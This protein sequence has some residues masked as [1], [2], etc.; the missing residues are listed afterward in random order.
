VA[1]VRV[2]ATALLAVLLAGALAVVP[3]APVLAAAAP[4]PP[5]E[6]PAEQ[7]PAGQAEPAAPAA[8]EPVE[9]AAG[10][11]GA[12]ETGGA[13][14]PT[15]PT[16]PAQPSETEPA[17]PSE[18]AE[19]TGSEPATE[20][21]ESSGSTPTGPSGSATQPGA[22]ESP[23]RDGTINGEDEDAAE[24][25]ADGGTDG[26]DGTQPGE[27]AQRAA[28]DPAAIDDR[29]TVRAGGTV[30]I[31][32]TA[33]DVTGDATVRVPSPPPG[34]T[35]VVGDAVDFTPAVGFKGDVAF[36]YELV[37]DGTVRATA[38][39]R[40]TVLPPAGLAAAD[41]HAVTR[42]ASEGHPGHVVD[43]LANDVLPGTEDG[44]VS[45]EIVAA[46][47]HGTASAG[48]CPFEFCPTGSVV[49]RPA[50]GFAGR[51]TFVYGLRAGGE[52]VDTATVTVDV[53]DLPEGSVVPVDDTITV[54]PG[55]TV[56]FDPTRNDVGASGHDVVTVREPSNG[57]LGGPPP[58]SENPNL[59]QY[60][61]DAG[62]A[63]GV[64]TFTYRLQPPVIVEA[65]P[66]GRV[67]V[68]RVPIERVPFD[69][70]ADI[71]VLQL[72]A[73][74]A[75]ETATVTVIVNAPIS[76]PDTATT[77]AGESVDV[78]VG[79]NDS[80]L[81]GHCLA[82]PSPQPMAG[83]AQAVQPGTVTYTPP[84][85]F[86]GT[87]EFV[88]GYTPGCEG[89]AIVART[90]VTV[91]V[92]PPTLADDAATT[93]AGPVAGLPVTI[94]VLAND[95]RAA[96]RFRLEVDQPAGGATAV[97]TPGEG[98]PVVRY[99]PRA[100][101]A[102][103][104][105]FRYR[106]LSGDATVAEAT[107]SVRVLR[108]AAADDAAFTTAGEAVTVDAGANDTLADGVRAVIVAEP[109]S[110]DA[111]IVGESRATFSYAPGAGFGA[112]DAFDYALVAADEDGAD[113]ELARAT[114]TVTRV[115]AV[116]DTAR[117]RFRL[118]VVVDVRANDVGVVEAGGAV[119]VELDPAPAGLAAVEVREGVVEV[120]PE[121]GF[122]GAAE[123]T[124]RLVHDGRT[125]DTGTVAVDVP[126]ATEAVADAAATD[127]GVA[128][129]VDV[130]ANDENAAGLDVVVS[131]APGRG[132]AEVG[133]DGRVTYTPG[134]GRA[135]G[136]RFGYALQVPGTGER[137]ATAEVVVT[138]RA[139][140][141]GDDAMTVLSGPV[142]RPEAVDVLAN[143]RFAAGFAVS[144]GDAAHGDA[145][146]E[147]DR[148]VRYTP[149]AGFAGADTVPY[150]LVEPDGSVAA[151]AV[152][153]VRVDAVDARD[154]AATTRVDEDIRLAVLAND[155]APSGVTVSLAAPGP[156]TGTVAVNADGSL[157]YRPTAV[158]TD[159]FR[160]SLTGVVRG[161]RVVLDTAVVRVTVTDVPPPGGGGP[162]PGDPDPGDPDPGDPVDPDPDPGAGTP[163]TTPPAT[164]RTPDDVRVRL[165]VDSASP[166]AEVEVT[167]SGCPASEPVI[168][169]VDGRVAARP[170]ANGDGEFRATVPAPDEVGRH[171]VAVTCG[172]GTTTSDL[173]VVVTT[174]Q[175]GTQA[176]AGAAAAAAALLLFFL[177]SGMGLNPTGR[178]ARP[179]ASPGKVREP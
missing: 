119:T 78:N 80:V 31:A 94:D 117:S 134:P 91:T 147:G 33:N 71:P 141:P 110:G 5:A 37:L 39:V 27:P 25:A 161:T 118:P 144:V 153:R 129:E 63:G 34:T 113:T 102:G 36:G 109:E 169:E 137:I 172:A 126:E 178:R 120:T 74:V 70:L 89:D 23:E 12:G 176:P 158:G 170:T 73:V 175:A 16:E 38:T 163:G 111:T 106:L 142:P 48:G 28:A 140:Q 41:D 15:E 29:A 43:V 32:V 151:S 88:Y 17:T 100:G 173:D 4:P 20:P 131:A 62:F 21:S 108:V 79:A 107:V 115:E 75:A 145:V 8:A 171:R 42:T 159:G 98:R 26:T 45:V 44:D 2:G 177:L 154:D 69:S 52:V 90:T 76:Q 47:A 18:P 59:V 164:P 96:R 60:T 3:A 179:A 124:Y 167:G 97:R 174:M 123:L 56:V 157:D 86:V 58:G 103:T 105:T 46:P 51:D 24:D 139:P 77:T 93:A 83:S 65:V 132:T 35:A 101:F 138:V 9:P 68:D 19:P 160:Y 128:V 148:V 127:A 146:L 57:R 122:S 7:A 10:T 135:G 64:D 1:R 125:V 53:G 149:D 66:L 67:P 155:V 55:E 114:V 87:D 150:D 116:P 40:V 6:A 49:Y 85:G 11:S 112:A 162:G 95:D 82:V 165:D 152:V 121:D 22:E 166:L 168:V 133:D 104:D 72:A 54:R 13:T 61:P 92:R 130:L 136:D 81:S 84:P 99:T 50:D 143:D 14:E 156:S 30:R